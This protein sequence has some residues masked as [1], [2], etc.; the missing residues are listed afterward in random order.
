[1][2]RRPADEGRDTACRDAPHSPRW[3]V[4]IELLDLFLALADRSSDAVTALAAALNSTSSSNS[5]LTGNVGLNSTDASA[6]NAALSK[7][8]LFLGEKD[9]SVMKLY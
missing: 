6:G 2:P 7:F 3:A 4:S 9:K 1:M 5:T 8:N